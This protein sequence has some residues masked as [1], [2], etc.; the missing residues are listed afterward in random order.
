MKWLSVA[1]GILVLVN[2][3]LSFILSFHALSELGAKTGAFPPELVWI[4]P[5]I[6]DGSIVCFSLAALRATL[7]KESARLFVGLILAATC[8][9]VVF[10]VLSIEQ[11]NLGKVLAAFPPI[12]LA[13]CFEVFL[14]QLRSGIER[15]NGH[16]TRSDSGGKRA[17]R[18][19]RRARV[20]DVTPK[21]A[22]VA[23]RQ[24]KVAELLKLGKLPEEIAKDLQVSERTVF[25]DAQKRSG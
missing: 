9:S 19:P 16:V 23:A 24:A 12:L 8:S 13:I 14:R 10:N 2:A 3:G 4:F 6:L 25:R 20:I 22:E 15:A 11:G 5:T 17:P 21:K 7:E 1:T 18:G